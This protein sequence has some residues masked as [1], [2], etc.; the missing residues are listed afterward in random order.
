VNPDPAELHQIGV[1]LVPGYI[2]YCRNVSRRSM[3]LS[4]ETGVFAY[5]LC[6]RNEAMDV[7]DLG[8]GWS[9]YFL[10]RYA[11]ES[12]ATVTSVDDDAYWL[13][14][15]RGFLHTHRTDTSNLVM[16]GD[17]R[18]NL[19]THDVI[20]HDFAAGELREESMRVAAERLMPGG[21]VVFDDAQHD[22]HRAAMYA[23]CDEYGLTP[24]DV[25]EWTCDEVHRYALAAVKP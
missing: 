12:G 1:S 5:W 2:D 4:I 17:Y 15:T 18:R 21:V 23:T 9:S 25:K 6:L 14:R 3:A 8:S 11:K 10:R 22:G 16:W 13:A 24:I 19:T 7:C 20:V